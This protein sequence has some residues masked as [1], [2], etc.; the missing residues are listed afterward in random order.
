MFEV[1]SISPFDDDWMERDTLIEKAAGRIS[2][3]S[4]AGGCERIMV[5]MLALLNKHLL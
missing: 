3:F 1:R 4:G 5:G 2:D